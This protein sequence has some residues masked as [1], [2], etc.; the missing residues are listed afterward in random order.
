MLKLYGSFRSRASRTLWMLAECGVPYEQEDFGKLEGEAKAAVLNRVNPLGKVPALEDGDLKLFESMAINLYLARKYGGRL[1][2]AGED[3][4]ARALSWSFFCMTELEPRMV[5]IFYER[6][7]R[8]EGERNADN[9]KKNWDD[10]QRPLKVLNDQ[11]QGRDFVLGSAFTVADLNLASCFTMINAMK[12]DMNAFPNVQRWLAA[13]Y[14]RP[15]YTKSR[16]AAP[17]PARA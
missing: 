2:P 5:Q 12:L 17:P 15:G 9:E 3:D 6:V 8:K 14:T 11:L 4:Q 10:L 7:V 16:P 1:W 13:C